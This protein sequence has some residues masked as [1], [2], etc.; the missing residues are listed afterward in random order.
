MD[1]PIAV[2]LGGGDII[3]EAARHHFIG[4]VDDAQRAIAIFRAV[5]DDAKRHDVGQ[6]LEADVA[7]LHLA[8]DRIGMLLAPRHGDR[9][10]AAAQQQ[11]QFRADAVDLVMAAFLQLLQPLGDAVIGVRFQLA[12]GQQLHLAHEIIHADPLGER[13][14]DVHRLLGD[15]AAL[16]FILDE[17]QRAHIVQPVGELDQQHAD[18]VGHGEQEFAQIFRRPL[19]FGH[20]FD[21]RQ[22]GDAIDHARDILAERGLYLFIGDQRVFDR[23]VQQGSDDGLIVEMEVGQYPRDFN[24]MAEIGVAARAFLAPMFLHRKHIGAVDHR[25]VRI[26]IVALYPFDKFILA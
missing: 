12:E 10:V 6:L 9:Q 2:A 26:G 22:L 15:A 16:G 19:I 21:F 18:I 14:I 13:G 4:L 17:M 24:R 3:L 1:R 25:F 23:V 7:L 20:G 5:G 8:P 11:L